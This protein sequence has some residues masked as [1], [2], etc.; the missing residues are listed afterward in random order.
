MKK[1]LTFLVCFLIYACPTAGQ[2]QQRVQAQKAARPGAAAYQLG[3]DAKAYFNAISDQTKLNAYRILNYSTSSVGYGVFSGDL[4][5]SNVLSSTYDTFSLEYIVTISIPYLFSADYGTKANWNFAV[6]GPI[7]YHFNFPYTAYVDFPDSV[8]PGQ[9]IYLA[10][11]FSWAGAQGDMP[12]LKA[13]QNY[14]YSMKSSFWFDAPDG[15]D[16]TKFSFDQEATKAHISA[17]LPVIPMYDAFHVAT[18]VNIWPFT[19]G[20]GDFAGSY[21]KL[22]GTGTL[23]NTNGGTFNEL[24]TGCGVYAV[25][26]SDAAWRQGHEQFA[27]AAYVLTTIPA[28]TP[29][30]AALNVV[31]ELGDFSLT[32]QLQGTIHRDDLFSLEIADLP[33]I[34]VPMN[35][36]LN[37]WWS[38]DKDVT[39]KGR[40]YGMSLFSYPMGFNTTFDMLGIDPETLLNLTA[41]EV[42]AGSATSD[43]QPCT[44]TFRISGKLPVKPLER[45]A[46]PLIHTPDKPL[47]STAQPVAQKLT[48]SPLAPHTTRLATLAETRKVV[49][50]SKT[51]AFPKPST[52]TGIPRAGQ[53]TVILGLASSTTAAQIRDALQ[54]KGINAFIVPVKDAQGVVVT[55]GSFADKK[56]AYTLSGLFGEGFKIR[57]FVSQSI[58]KK[59]YQPLGDDALRKIQSK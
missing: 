43:W 4:T 19:T 57:S 40:V 34:D 39:V 58:D 18:D 47:A 44:S 17:D 56:Q 15:F 5:N 24:T 22:G 53:Y 27:L 28:T 26:T 42:S 12:T 35:A 54:K 30:G 36:M 49:R 51:V 48:K 6:T 13:T 3:N 9:R 29:A 31:R 38:F 20:G 33:Y 21:T 32:T 52:P 37:G 2:I 7:K 16:A 41:T 14:S 23:E 10:P 59:Y 50:R 55:L 1:S 11:T 25:G 46:A 45:I 8:F